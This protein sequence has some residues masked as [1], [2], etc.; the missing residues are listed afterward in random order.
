MSRRSEARGER[1]LPV[2]L[3]VRIEEDAVGGWSE[4]TYT[5][6][7]NSRGAR[8]LSV[9]SWKAGEQLRLTTRHHHFRTTARVIYCQRL[10]G[11]D[12]FA[13]GLRFTGPQGQ[14]VVAAPT[15]QPELQP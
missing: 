7:V 15:A 14:W 3:V 13:L 4:R 9:R 12:N 1:R 11:S 2:S 8:V 5:D 6:N 10:N